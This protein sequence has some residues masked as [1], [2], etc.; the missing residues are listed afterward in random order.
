MVLSAEDAVDVFKNRVFLINIRIKQACPAKIQFDPEHTRSPNVVEVIK[1]N[2]GS[3]G[4]DSIPLF[5]VLGDKDKP[6]FSASMARNKLA[7]TLDGIQE[8]FMKAVG[9]SGDWYVPESR[10]GD[11][12]GAIASELD[13]EI[14][15]QLGYFTDYYDEA[16][17]LFKERLHNTLDSFDLLDWE[18]YYLAQF[19]SLEAIASNFGYE[20][21][22]WE[23][24][25][26]LEEVLQQAAT[27]PALKRSAEVLESQIKSMQQDAPKLQDEALGHLAAIALSLENADSNT[28]DWG[29]EYIKLKAKIER[30]DVINDLWMGIFRSSNSLIAS[31]VGEFRM[32]CDRLSTEN[33]DATGLMWQLR[34]EWQGVLSVPEFGEGAIA[35]THW[36]YPEQGLQHQI[37]ETEAKLKDESLAQ[38]V[39]TRLENKLADLR[40]SLA[41]IQARNGEAPELSAQ[42]I[43]ARATAV[44]KTKKHKEPK[45]AI[46]VDVEVIGEGAIALLP[47][48]SSQVKVDIF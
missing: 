33:L 35:F 36:L 41:L 1:S 37:Q 40:E 7:N 18:P 44:M 39:R 9:Q 2:G 3:L 28:D 27:D 21:Q 38:K 32:L 46:A 29:M 19:P 23:P 31:V 22:K 10:I 20:V 11:L 8:R 24:M 4:K 43:A 34:D 13:A 5:E 42:E 17:S 30:V 25:K 15:I 16:E 12:E 45:G 48:S 26:S 47:E 14:A 6:I